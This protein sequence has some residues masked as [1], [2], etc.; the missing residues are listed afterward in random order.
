MQLQKPVCWLSLGC[1]IA[2]V[3]LVLLKTGLFKHLV[4]PRMLGTWCFALLLLDV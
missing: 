2:D 1:L 4:Y 3:L